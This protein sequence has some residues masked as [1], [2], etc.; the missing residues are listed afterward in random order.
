MTLNSAGDCLRCAFGH[1]LLDHN[2]DTKKHLIAFIAYFG[3]ENYIRRES[4]VELQGTLKVLEDKNLRRKY[5]NDIADKIIRILVN[6][7]KRHFSF[8]NANEMFESIDNIFIPEWA[9]EKGLFLINLFPEVYLINDHIYYITERNDRCYFRRVAVDEIRKLDEFNEEPCVEN[10]TYSYTISCKY[11]DIIGFNLERQSLYLKLKNTANMH[12]E[13]YIKQHQEVLHPY[14]CLGILGDIFPVIKDGEGLSFIVDGSIKKIKDY[15][16]LE[17]YDIRKDHIYVEAE[18][19]MPCIFK[20]YMLSIDGTRTELS[21]SSLARY[22][23]D[24][25]SD[26]IASEDDTFRFFR[27]LNK[28]KTRSG[29]GEI[30]EPITLNYIK[31][32]LEE[33]NP[34]KNKVA[35]MYHFLTKL[36]S[37]YYE[38]D[39]DLLDLLYALSDASIRM[40]ED[41]IDGF[42]SESI[43]WKLNELHFANKLKN[44]IKKP[45]RLKE[46]LLENAFW[47]D[48]RLQK[49]RKNHAEDKTVKVGSFSFEKG[50]LKA[51]AVE[52]NKAVI[53]GSRL[54]SPNDDNAGSIDYDL[55]TGFVEIAY[56]RMLDRNE[57]R[58]LVETFCIGEI[59]YRVVITGI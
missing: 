18:E 29:S 20:P 53:R 43:Y 54:C 47:N 16:N 52:L 24:K 13:Y 48:E 32:L 3:L 15:D 59:P 23:V 40:K 57:M 34:E 22:I 36:L 4:V 56:K 42:I 27:L 41:H 28:D 25:I 46:I 6:N 50:I 12:A 19:S 45:E 10:Q 49:L 9:F 33:H 58:K 14:P 11:S 7:L 55:E 26:D 5:S 21:Y 17:H 8:S 35:R 44:T 39:E 2:D 30:K 38:P 31:S 1:E 51:N 37:N